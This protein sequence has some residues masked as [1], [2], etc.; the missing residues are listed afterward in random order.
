MLNT[1]DKV[2]LFLMEST[3]IM[4]ALSQ[5]DAIY[6]HEQRAFKRN[7][8]RFV[9]CCNLTAT[10]NR[11]TAMKIY[12]RFVGGYC[13]GLEPNTVIIMGM[14]FEEL[15]ESIHKDEP[16][17]EQQAILNGAINYLLK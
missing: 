14:L 2:R 17:D 16:K 5:S 7:Y 11:I 1:D 4:R 3:R 10:I 15:A 9:L 13:E 8:W 12:A 6:T